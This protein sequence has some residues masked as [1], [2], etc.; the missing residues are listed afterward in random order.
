M[1]YF[2]EHITIYV[3]IF[4]LVHLHFNHGHI[5]VE[6]GT[7][8][9]LVPVHKLLHKTKENAFCVRQEHPVE[10]NLTYNWIQTRD[11][12]ILAC[13]TEGHGAV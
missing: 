3:L 4:T 2:S 8:Y 7:L 13:G 6:S 10:Q 9:M 1:Q 12:S 11:V 5:P